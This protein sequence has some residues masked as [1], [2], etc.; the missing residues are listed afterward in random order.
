MMADASLTVYQE[1]CDFIYV[2]KKFAASAIFEACI[3]RL[4][5]L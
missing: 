3:S 4:T 2:L 1:N 5:N